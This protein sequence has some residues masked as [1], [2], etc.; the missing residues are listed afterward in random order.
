MTQENHDTNDFANPEISNF[1][2]NQLHELGNLAIR[3]GLILGHGYHQG[4]YEILHKTEA[5]LLAPQAA[6]AY[7][8]SLLESHL[9]ANNG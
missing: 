5:V 7:L 9:E 1:D 6:L 8:K 3:Q 2:S 4:Q